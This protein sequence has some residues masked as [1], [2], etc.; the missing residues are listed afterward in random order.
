M[1]QT[2]RLKV[3]AKFMRYHK[4]WWPFF[5]MA[6]KMGLAVEFRRPSY[7]FMLS[8]SPTAPD[9][10]P[11]RVPAPPRQKSGGYRGIS[12]GGGGGSGTPG[13]AGECRNEVGVIR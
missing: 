4:N 2:S 11:G 12:G 13:S 10:G 8:P 5:K 6:A 7:F 1:P 3:M 9:L